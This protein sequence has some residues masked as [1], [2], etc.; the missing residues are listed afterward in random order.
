MVAMGRG[1]GGG[2]GDLMTFGLKEVDLGGI[3]SDSVLSQDT[4]HSLE[5]PWTQ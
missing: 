5:S 1:G 3:P 2:A 4:W